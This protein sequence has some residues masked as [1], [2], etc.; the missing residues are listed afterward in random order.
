M[1]STR[2]VI[3][4]WSNQQLYKLDDINVTLNEIGYDPIWYC[5]GISIY[6]TD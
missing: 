6:L 1:Y 2:E 5:I 3:K 4:F